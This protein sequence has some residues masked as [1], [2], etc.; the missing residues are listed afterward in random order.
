MEIFIRMCVFK[1]R[2][3]VGRLILELPA[4]M[5]NGDNGDFVG[6][7]VKEVEEETGIRLN[8]E[9]V[10]DLTALLDPSTGCRVF[11]S[12]GGCDD[13]ISL[14]LYRRRVGKELSLSCKEK[15]LVFVN[16]VS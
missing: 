2:V 9:D 3:P 7:A 4:G 12:P 8:L 13:E 10:V 16:R 14:F 11:P 1:A 6:T 5:L 15:K